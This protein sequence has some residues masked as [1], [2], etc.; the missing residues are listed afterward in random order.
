MENVGLVEAPDEPKLELFRA[1]SLVPN[2]IRAK[3]R[4]GMKTSVRAARGYL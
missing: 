2:M 4:L 1:P 3:L